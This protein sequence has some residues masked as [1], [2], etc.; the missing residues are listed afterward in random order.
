M[1]QPTVVVAAR[2][3][4]TRIILK[5][6]LR[7]S[8]YACVTAA[9]GA[10]GLSAVVH[11]PGAALVISELYLPCGEREFVE[12]LRRHPSLR[13]VPVLIYDAHTFPHDRLHATALGCAAFIAKPA[14]LGTVL[15]EV[16]RLV[17]PCVTPTAGAA[18]SPAPRDTPDSR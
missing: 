18:V 17:G 4:D 6:A 12:V 16:R 2:D 5:T 3:E 10:T 7:A 14:A 8:G 15:E 11:T 1:P 9:D 13:R